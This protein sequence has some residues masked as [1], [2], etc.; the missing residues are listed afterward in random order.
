[1][2]LALLRLSACVRFSYATLEPRSGASKGAPEHGWEQER[3][4]RNMRSVVTY[5]PVMCGRLMQQP[6]AADYYK[7]T[8][9][10]V[11]I[12]EFV[13]SSSSSVEKGLQRGGQ[14]DGAQRGVGG[15]RKETEGEGERGMTAGW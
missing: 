9:H 6:V 2:P 10:L 14:E 4:R 1:M 5:L 7:T 8:T 13:E 15:S 12:N 3:M 11:D